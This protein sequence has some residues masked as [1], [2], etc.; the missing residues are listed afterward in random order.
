MLAAD[1]R[2]GLIEIH[3][4]QPEVV[5]EDHQSDH[6][7]ARQGTLGHGIEQV[8][9]GVIGQRLQ[10]V[11]VAGPLDVCGHLQSS[12]RALSVQRVFIDLVVGLAADKER[13]SRWPVADAL[14]VAV[15]QSAGAIAQVLDGRD[16]LPCGVDAD[17]CQSEAVALGLV[18][19]QGIAAVA[20]WA[21]AAVV[22]LGHQLA[23]LLLSL[24]RNE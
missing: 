18:V 15:G 7:L 22:A 21:Y 2:V 1:G 13:L 23:E 8:T 9:A 17:G 11:V 5:A 16:A 3:V 19:H 4:L 6:L 20:Q 12:P 24:G 14:H 10:S